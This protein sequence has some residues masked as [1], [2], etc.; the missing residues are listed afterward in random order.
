M[1]YNNHK[2]TLALQI[3]SC[4]DS[5][6]V[7]VFIPA[8]GYGK[9]MGSLTQEI[10]KPLLTVSG[11]PLIHIALFNAWRWGAT[12]AIINTHYLGEKIIDNLKNF[13]HFKIDFS[14]EKKEILGTAGGIKTGISRFW[15]NEDYFLSINPDLVLFPDENFNPMRGNFRRSSL[16]YLHPKEQ[17]DENTSLD[18]QNGKVRFVKGNLFYIGLGVF[19][20]S[21]LKN[22]P[23]ESYYDLVNIF[24]DLEAAG[25]LEG[26]LF[27][28]QVFDA[29]DRA[30]YEKMNEIAL[31]DRIDHKLFLEFQ[32]GWA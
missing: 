17:G 31:F 14:E 16:L 9:R 26:S 28:G 25:E 11:V 24:H 6:V 7:K 32:K 19:H 3:F 30:K 23:V 18:L 2:N 21:I 20:S 22:V 12:G 10:P 4:K 5:L 1:E 8:A 29:G 27:S 13:P 15:K